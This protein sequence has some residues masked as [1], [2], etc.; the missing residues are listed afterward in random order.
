VAAEQGNT[1]MAAGEHE[2]AC[3]LT[4]Q[5]PTPAGRLPTIQLELVRARLVRPGDTA[6]VADA[7]AALVAAA[8]GWRP[9]GFTAAQIDAA[10]LRLRTWLDGGADVQ[11]E[12]A[13]SEAPVFVLA[14]A[15][16]L[17]HAGA[18]A[19]AHACAAP[20]AEALEP[21][22]ADPVAVGALAVTAAACDAEGDRGT[23]AR[24]AEQALDLA[25]PEGIRLA[26]AD[27]APAIEPVLA[28]LLR[29]GTTHRSLIGEVLE[30]ART[31][32]TG[33]GSAAVAP[34]RE[35]LSVREL[36]VLRYLPT[37]LTS[38]EIAGELFV[39]LNTVKSHLKSIYRKLDAE[40]RRDAV[41]RA[42]ELGLVAPSGL[43]A[44]ARP[45]PLSPPP[46]H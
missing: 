41:R 14:N 21:G 11:D 26:I 32:T 3:E 28:H 5:L 46:P 8:A 6:G 13:G 10:R 22:A 19:E 33:A 7:L 2:R 9:P 42:R 15:V 27:A 24:V 17:L 30:L 16:A 38:Q 4:A 37:M 31:G 20:L 12:P 35:E 43:A 23:A 34:L 44:E 40:G 1:L 36:A 25:E 45:A 29:Y 39:T 18:P